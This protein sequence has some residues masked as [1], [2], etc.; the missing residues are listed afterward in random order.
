M[1]RDRLVDFARRYTA[2]WCS[3]E[4]EQ[5]AQHY[6]PTG[7]L[8]INNGAPSIGR[9]QITHAAQAFMSAFPD[10]QVLMDDL[11][12]DDRGIEYHWTLIGTNTGPGGTAMPSASAA[13]R[14]GRSARTG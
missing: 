6:A 8:T 3:G 14:N 9:T 11:R 5:V 12:T 4:P 1:D 13:L 2:A 7:S 10:L